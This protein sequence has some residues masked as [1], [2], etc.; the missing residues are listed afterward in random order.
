MLNEFWFEIFL[1]IV[2]ILAVIGCI[3]AAVFFVCLGLY[4][5]GLI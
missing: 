3:V 1:K 4:A 2:F 5:L